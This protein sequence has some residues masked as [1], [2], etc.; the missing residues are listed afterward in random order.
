MWCEIQDVSINRKLISSN[1][2][3]FMV[4][5]NLMM[6]AMYSLEQHENNAVYAHKK[7]TTIITLKI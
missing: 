2:F 1:I 3:Q 7:G 4:H 6:Q 5:E